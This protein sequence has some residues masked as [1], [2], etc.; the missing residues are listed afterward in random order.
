LNLPLLKNGLPRKI[1]QPDLKSFNS[2]FMP[3]LRISLIQ[4]PLY[5]EDKK[6]NLA[7]LEEKIA[8]LPNKPEL[9][10]LP[11]MFSTGFSMNVDSLGETMTGPT[12][13]WMRSVAARKTSILTGSIIIKDE[14]G[15]LPLF[16]NRLIWMLPTGEYGIYNKRHLFAYGK[17]DKY[18][19]A[20]KS[21]FVAS[22][23]KWKVNLQICYDLRFPVWS[24]QS[25]PPGS[26]PE[27]EYDLLVV[28]ANWP[29]VR[30]HAWKTLLQARA[31]EN[32][33]YVVGVNRIG[34]DGNGLRYT[35]DSMVVSPLG[36]TIE[37][38]GEAEEAISHILDR[39][40]LDEIRQKFPFLRDA[41]KFL[42]QP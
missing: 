11:E 34:I 26:S 3:D 38:L 36:E 42:I 37:I 29:T 28:V 4:T 9:I 30:S 2:Y 8:A 7:M 25:N 17:E 40:K 41:D 24:R 20:G 31:I 10:I 23:N 19:S 35:G 27:T 13:E 5:W 22:V 6:A 15:E 16:Y 12:I 1:I 14:T 18:F 32:Q 21:R 39:N 33:C